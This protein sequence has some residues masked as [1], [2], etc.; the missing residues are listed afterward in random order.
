MGDAE[1][2]HLFMESDV[3][4]V[5]HAGSRA[6]EHP[7]VDQSNQGFLGSRMNWPASSRMMRLASSIIAAGG[8]VG[9][10]ESDS[11]AA[12]FAG[13]ISVMLASVASEKLFR[14]AVIAFFCF[15]SD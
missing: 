6:E 8:E 11:S 9:A 13:V 3:D 2:F 4:R 10:V 1:L 15:I 5:F 7:S 12:A 14:A